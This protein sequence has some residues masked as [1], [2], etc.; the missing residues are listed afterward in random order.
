MSTT[1]TVDER[2]KVVIEITHRHW[3][4]ADKIRVAGLNF[5]EKLGNE[6]LVTELIENV[7]VGKV[8]CIKVI[9]VQCTAAVDSSHRVDGRGGGG[10]GGVLTVC[11]YL[12]VHNASAAVAGEDR[13][14]AAICSGRRVRRR[15]WSEHSQLVDYVR[16]LND[17]RLLV[18]QLAVHEQVSNAGV[19]PVHVQRVKGGIGGGGG[20][21]G[22]L[23]RRVVV[24]F[25]LNIQTGR[26]VVVRRLLLVE[27]HLPTTRRTI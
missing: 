27:V 15:R 23:L 24:Q 21:D 6:F 19:Q 11:D 12:P 20:G 1:G 4:V 22:R 14:D 7:I 8:G 16:L 9:K 5:L 10:G 17:A 25:T 26:L 13:V 3:A 2:T 18:G